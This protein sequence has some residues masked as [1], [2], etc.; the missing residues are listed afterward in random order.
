MHQLL[1]NM[2]QLGQLQQLFLQLQLRCRCEQMWNQ[3][4]RSYFIDYKII[5]W[6]SQNLQTIN[7]NNFLLCSLYL[8]SG[9]ERSSSTSFRLL[10]YRSINPWKYLWGYFDQCSNYHRASLAETAAP[11]ILWTAPY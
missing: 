6:I 4:K 3:E 11:L 9:Q 8:M 10:A 2:Q 1:C 7:F 5:R